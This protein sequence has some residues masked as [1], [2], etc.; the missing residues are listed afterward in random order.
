M[1]HS[2][3]FNFIA[4]K[5]RFYV[6]GSKKLFGV[7]LLQFSSKFTDTLLVP[8]TEETSDWVGTN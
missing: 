7:V 5:I 4:Q 6:D 1:V 3:N 2:L 8:G